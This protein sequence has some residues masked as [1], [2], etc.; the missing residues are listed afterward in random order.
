MG[1]W[2]KM[3]YKESIK[4]IHKLLSNVALPFRGDAEKFYPAFYKCISDAENPFGKGL[5]KHASLFLGFELANYILRCLT[6]GSLEKDSVDQFK[7]SLG[8]CILFYS[9]CFRRLRISK[10]E[11]LE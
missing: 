5:N 11:S 1:H 9:L 8:N 2:F 4:K 6:G 10:K 3:T 7:Y